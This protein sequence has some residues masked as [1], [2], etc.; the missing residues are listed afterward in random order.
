[1]SSAA[2]AGPAPTLDFFFFFVGPTQAWR[3][4]FSYS[5][6]HEY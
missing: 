5:N 3:I 4:E 1:M 2:A 6:I